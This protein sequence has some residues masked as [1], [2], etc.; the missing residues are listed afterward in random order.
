MSRYLWCLLAAA[1]LL[2]SPLS[3]ARSDNDGLLTATNGESLWIAEYEND[4]FAGEDRY[5]TSG[6][7]LTRIAL[8]RE[9]PSW[10]ESVATRFP[11]FNDATALP[12]AL[13]IS[14]N[15]YTPADIENPEFPP[16]DRPY[17]AWLQLGF[18]TGTLHP[19]G[20]D[21]VRV[22][23][24]IVGPAA[25]GR[26]VQTNAH[27]LIGSPKPQGWGSQLKN[28]PTLSVGYDRF[29][30]VID[31]SQPDQFGFDVSWLAGG[32]AGNALTHLTGGS[33]IRVGQNLPD[34][35]GPPRI[36]PAVSGSG[37]FRPGA[38]RSF[39]AF[40]GVEARVVGRDLFIEGNTIGGRDGVDARR[41]VGETYAGVVYTRDRLRLAYTHVWRN[42]EF[43]GQLDGQDY[44]AL[45]FSLWW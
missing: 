13:S 29:R 3:F 45:S 22:G 41:L 34:D 27:R 36:S 17:A 43:V 28:E 14:H 30:R 39:Y 19:R 25:L 4:I 33:F 8:A 5:Y 20:A 11:G 24:G 6:V 35:F 37:F 15:I 2:G 21:R 26:E 44:G 18:S 1:T 23:L 32:T 31:R 9:A 12:Y 38:E 7:R 40:W 10:L 42:R 16:D